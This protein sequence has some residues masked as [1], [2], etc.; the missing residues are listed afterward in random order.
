MRELV[1]KAFTMMQYKIDEHEKKWRM[2]VKVAGASL[3]GIVVFFI[4]PF[5]I[6]ELTNNAMFK[7]EPLDDYLYNEVY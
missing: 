4:L 6:A 7:R 1:S 3:I 2:W 5:A